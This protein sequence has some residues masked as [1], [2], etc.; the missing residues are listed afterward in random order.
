MSLPVTWH[1]NAQSD[2]Y[3]M[4]DWIVDRAGP[5][6]AISYTRRIQER[7]RS[8]ADFPHRGTPREDLGLALRSITFQ[9][10]VVI[11]YRVEQDRVLVLRLIRAARDI[12]AQFAR[13]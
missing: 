3:Q 13:D 12:P 4:Y 11:V 7:C 5:E 1:P 9:R 10:R 6:I 8:L 2:L